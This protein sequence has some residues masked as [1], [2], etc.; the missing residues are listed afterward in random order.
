MKITKSVK[1][2]TIPKIK[3]MHNIPNSPKVTQILNKY[4]TFIQSLQYIKCIKSSKANYLYYTSQLLN[5]LIGSCVLNKGKLRSCGSKQNISYDV[6]K[7]ANAAFLKMQG[8]QALQKSSLTSSKT[9][10]RNDSST[11]FSVTMQKK[12]PH[13]LQRVSHGPKG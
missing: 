10:F 2:P 9:V 4:K 5:P 12:V 11:D 6:K 3:K 7:E 13:F 8:F 1:I